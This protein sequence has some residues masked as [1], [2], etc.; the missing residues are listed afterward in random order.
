MSIPTYPTTPTEEM[1]LNQR[2]RSSKEL[3]LF[4]FFFNRRALNIY[5]LAP[6]VKNGKESPHNPEDLGLTAGLGRSPEEGNGNPLQY[7]C[8]ENAMDRGAWQAI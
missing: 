8:L 5:L 1:K 2:M 6:L 7:S 4:F 3:F